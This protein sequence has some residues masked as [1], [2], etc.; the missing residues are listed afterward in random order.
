MSLIEGIHQS[1]FR[2]FVSCDLVSGY[3]WTVNNSVF[4]PRVRFKYLWS[5]GCMHGACIYMHHEF[6]QYPWGYQKKRF[7]VSC[8]SPTKK[9]LHTIRGTITC[10]S[11]EGIK[12][13]SFP[14]SWQCW[15][16]WK[17]ITLNFKFSTLHLWGLWKKEVWHEEKFWAV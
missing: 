10:N 9:T 1:W 12:K 5:P 15:Q 13:L 2:I 4:R 17:E 16:Y 8:Y 3:L 7:D 11:A 6:L 14:E